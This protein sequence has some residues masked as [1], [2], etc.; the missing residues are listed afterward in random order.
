MRVSKCTDI[1]HI[2]WLLSG[3]VLS[4]S[5]GIMLGSRSVNI[6]DFYNDGETFHVSTEAEKIKLVDVT[7]DSLSGV[8]HVDSDDAKLTFQRGKK[9][10]QYYY[11]YLKAEK[12]NR[13]GIRA[14]FGFYNESGRRVCNYEN[15]IGNG[16]NVYSLPVTGEFSRMKIFLKDQTGL[17]FSVESVSFR[18]KLDTFSKKRFVVGSV[19][20]FCLYLLFTG[21]ILRRDSKKRRMERTAGSLLKKVNEILNYIYLLEEK[22]ASWLCRH[23]SVNHR[24]MFRIFLLSILQTYFFV[25][26]KLGVYNNKYTKYH[27]LLAV[28]VLLLAAWSMYEGKLESRIWDKE[29][30]ESFFIFCMILCVC[31]GWMGSR[32]LCVGYIMLFAMG[33]LFFFWGNQQIV[34]REQFIN[35]L[36]ISGGVAIGIQ[37]LFSIC[38][39]DFHGLFRLPMDVGRQ[40]LLNAWKTY[41]GDINLLGH[42]EFAETGGVRV[43]A[44]NAILQM[45]HRYGILVLVPYCMFLAHTVK[46]GI[47]SG[48][49]KLI[50][51]EGTFL[52]LVFITEAEIPFLT[53]F[54]T[55]FYLHLGY[56]LF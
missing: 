43:N 9:D 24:H 21:F 56:F 26:N 3:L 11:L 49:K 16:W 54:W 20:I 15:A 14:V 37:L 17:E 30:F 10:V 25:V 5:I 52:L 7:Y 50:L 2:A 29:Y 13:D 33:S 55:M 39:M 31:D 4:L 32:Y 44:Y 23:L 34:Q 8:Y 41:A 36:L 38:I 28:L 48:K 51:I 53:P 19:G 27:M 45:C 35:E 42:S 47:L 18:Q 46:K 6:R 1:R 22:P 40:D 12:I